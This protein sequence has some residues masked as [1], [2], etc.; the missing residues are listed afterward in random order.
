MHDH[1]DHD[2]HDHD[3]RHGAADQ[4]PRFER[5]WARFEHQARR[6]MRG[7]GLN[8]FDWQ[9]FSDNFR[10][11]RM[12]AGGDL[13]LVA[14]YL[15]DQQP[16][17]GYDLIKAIEEK[18]AGFYAPSPGTIYPALTFL[19]EAGYV[20]S[21]A[22]GNKRSYTIT[23]AGRAHLADNRAAVEATLDYLG[24]VGRRMAEMK[25]K[26][27]AFDESLKS[28]MRA[29]RDIPDVDPAVNAARRRL[30][31]AIA[32]GLGRGEDAQR[33]LAGILDRAAAEIEALDAAEPGDGIDL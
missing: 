14:L 29:D 18:T 32:G 1:H 2:H 11:G 13:R 16:R 33:R 24:R 9:G 27:G 20:T 10:I 3:H 7:F 26:V 15:I 21:S 25:E 12:L 31:A 28:G 4:G 19:E 17:H 22:E 6:A 8:G 30:K 5:R 23:E